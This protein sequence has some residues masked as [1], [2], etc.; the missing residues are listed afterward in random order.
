[1]KTLV[2]KVLELSDMR[3]VKI[4]LLIYDNRFHKMEEIWSHED[5]KLEKVCEMMKE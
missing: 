2:K 1:M 5:M 4:N 3:Q